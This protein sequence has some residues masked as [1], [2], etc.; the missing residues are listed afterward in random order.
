MGSTARRA[1]TL[2]KRDGVAVGCKRVERRMREAELARDLVGRDFTASAPNRLWAT[3]LTMISTGE[4][5]L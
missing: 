3:D 4:G 2:L 5:P 1:C